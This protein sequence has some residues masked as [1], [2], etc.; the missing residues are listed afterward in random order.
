MTKIFLVIILALFIGISNCLDRPT[1]PT[2]C[3]A[4]N[5]EHCEC[6]DES[7]GFHTYIF[8]VGDQL[9][10]FT[11]F[12]PKSRES[13]SLPV[14][15]SSNCYAKDQLNGIDMTN[16]I[17]AGNRAATRFGYVRIGLSSPTG[18]WHGMGNDGWYLLLIS[19]NFF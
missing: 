13:E 2:P 7:K 10:C 17:S 1:E 15:F 5:H 3:T 12:Y 4:S 14:F 8:Y 18:S 6:G 19:R 16:E 11:V 9:R